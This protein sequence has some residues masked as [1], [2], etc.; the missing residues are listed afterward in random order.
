[1]LTPAEL[2]ALDDSCYTLVPLGRLVLAAG[3]FVEDRLVPIGAWVA[4]RDEV[5]GLS[6]GRKGDG[7]AGWVVEGRRVDRVAQV[8]LGRQEGR[9]RV[10]LRHTR[11]RDAVLECVDGGPDRQ[12]TRPHPR[13]VG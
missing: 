1:M 10:A 4:Q 9:N 2:G 11:L 12:S 8:C 7:P 13:E 6:A 3:R 5:A